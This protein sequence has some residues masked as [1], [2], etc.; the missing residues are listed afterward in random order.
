M[1]AGRTTAAQA[2]TDKGGLVLFL[3][4]Y[5]EKP[6][7]EVLR[8][9]AAAPADAPL[10]KVFPEWNKLPTLL[11]KSAGFAI[12]AG[13]APL[14]A[15][16]VDKP[17]EQVERRLRAAPRDKKVSGVFAPELARRLLRAGPA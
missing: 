8:A 15:I 13:L 4:V 1:S 12:D 5:L 10:F 11:L 17:V 2:R 3:T 6:R 14:V 16:A 9:L 7:D